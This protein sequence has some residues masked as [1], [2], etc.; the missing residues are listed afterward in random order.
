VLFVLFGSERETCLRGCSHYSVGSQFSVIP[1]LVRAALQGAGGT[2]LRSGNPTEG[3][4]I[5]NLRLGGLRLGF[6]MV[7]E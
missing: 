2:G 1:Y 3:D 4:F 5:L 6:V 7:G